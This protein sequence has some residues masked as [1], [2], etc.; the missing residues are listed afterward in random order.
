[1]GSQRKGGSWLL[2]PTQFQRS[3]E[4]LLSLFSSYF[5]SPQPCPRQSSTHSSL[6]PCPSMPPSSIYSSTIIFLDTKDLFTLLFLLVSSTCSQNFSDCCIYVSRLLQPRA[7][8]PG[9]SVPYCRRQG[10][11]PST[12]DP[13]G[14]LV[15]PLST[16][17]A[18]SRPLARSCPGWRPPGCQRHHRG[19]RA[20]SSSG[21]SGWHP[22]LLAL[23]RLVGSRLYGCTV[24]EIT[25]SF[26]TL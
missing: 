16:T 18:D 26:G 2:E 1:M 23:S 12:A 25:L 6:Q 19:R 4:R 13:Q 5:N 22:G 15:P 14:S 9:C 11:L 21:S 8:S 17:Y 3:P 7:G 10:T 24:H 20:A